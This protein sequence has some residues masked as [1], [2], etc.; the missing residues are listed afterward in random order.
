M[1]AMRVCKIRVKFSAP[2]DIPRTPYHRHDPGGHV[3]A[4]YKESG[5]KIIGGTSNTLIPEEA[6]D[7]ARHVASREGYTHYQVL[8]PSAAPMP[9]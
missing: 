6:W 8:G 1:D 7:R 9:L 5:A 4:I 3:Y 2:L